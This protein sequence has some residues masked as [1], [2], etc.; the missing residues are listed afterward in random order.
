MSKRV[1]TRFTRYE[2][3][4]GR[5]RVVKPK[6]PKKPVYRNPGRRRVPPKV[7]RRECPACHRNVKLIVL[8]RTRVLSYDDH[9]GRRPS[10]NISDKPCAMALQPVEATGTNT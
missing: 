1:R 2:F 4:D 6:P 8:F 7:V 3:R 9:N 5:Y 10:G